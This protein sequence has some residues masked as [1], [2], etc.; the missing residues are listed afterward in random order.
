MPVLPPKLQKKREERL[1]IVSTLR[2][3]S[4]NSIPNI[5]G[6]WAIVQK[7]KL[8]KESNS[9][10]KKAPIFFFFLEQLKKENWNQIWVTTWEESF[11]FW[12]VHHVGKNPFS[13][14]LFSTIIELLTLL[15][16]IK[17]KGA[18]FLFHDL[19]SSS[20]TALSSC[21]C[22]CWRR[23]RRKE[24]KGGMEREQE[25]GVQS[26]S[27]LFFFFFLRKHML[28]SDWS[29]MPLCFS[30]PH[31]AI[32]DLPFSCLPPLA[33]SSCPTLLVSQP[34]RLQISHKSGRKKKEEKKKKKKTWCRVFSN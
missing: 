6:K 13:A 17:K 12:S 10:F 34:P 8:G 14:V 19:P 21:C 2:C 3:W 11:P 25:G 24:G 7:V 32:D 5:F 23:G 15:K 27:W 33:Y 28:R 4:F 26:S 9:S 30:P 29:K 22:C 20:I 18:G 31:F 1:K 16:K